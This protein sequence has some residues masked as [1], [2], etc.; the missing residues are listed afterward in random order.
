MNRSTPQSAGKP[1]EFLQDVAA[2]SAT[3]ALLGTAEGCNDQVV[4]AILSGWRYD[5]SEVSPATRTEY[6]AHLIEC[7]HCRA[8]QRLHR[9]IDILLLA[10]FTLSF[11]A[12]L[13]A[14]AIIHREPWG[15]TALASLHTGRLSFAV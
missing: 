14:T 13:L 15:Q 9:S 2:R 11:F 4:G 12:F 3:A 5:L 7:Y 6:E 10:V 1:A 8:R